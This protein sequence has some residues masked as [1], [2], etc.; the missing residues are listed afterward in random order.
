MKILDLRG[1][2]EAPP[3]P[4]RPKKT[5]LEGWQEQL[6]SDHIVSPPGWHSTATERAHVGLYFFLVAIKSPR[7]ISSSSSMWVTFQKAHLV[8]PHRELTTGDPIMM[9]R[10]D[11]AYGNQHLHLGRLRLYLQYCP[12]RNPNQWMYISVKPSHICSH[13]PGNSVHS[14][15]WF[16]TPNKPSDLT[17]CSAA[18]LRHGS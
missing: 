16:G 13:W 12:S 1:E 6:H 10:R 11:G 3:V 8:L 9:G 15:A 18:P 2:V 4:Q 5:A 17:V 7:W 14:S